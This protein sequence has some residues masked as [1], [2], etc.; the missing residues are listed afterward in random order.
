[1]SK[2]SNLARRSIN[3]DIDLDYLPK[4]AARKVV[5]RSPHRS[6]GI[7][8]CSW[9]QEIGIEYESQLERRFLQLALVSP[10]I[11]KII[12]QPFKFEYTEH[13]KSRSYI[14]DFLLFFKDGG[15]IVVE[16]KPAKFVEKNRGKFNYAKS[17]LSQK[18]I[19]FVVVTD[20]QIH[21]GTAA[22]SAALLLR[23]ARG[24]ISERSHVSCMQVAHAATGSISLGSLMKEA[25][26]SFG[27]VLHLI[28]RGHLSTPA[29]LSID[30]ATPITPTAQGEEN[31]TICFC[32]WFNVT[33]W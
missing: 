26:V 3:S 19:P 5:T 11:K 9:I 17:V 32:N 33:P 2:N 29:P 21:A 10:H 30:V 24:Q 16:V 15:K 27:E 18:K 12:H 31:G 28:A 13:E 7:M 1:M 23:Y 14:P 8:A 20:K 4:K 25:D 6:V 22:S